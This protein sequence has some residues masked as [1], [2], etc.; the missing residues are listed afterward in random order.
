MA[1]LYGAF[2]EPGNIVEKE[3]RSL[4]TSRTEVKSKH[5]DSDLGQ[6]SS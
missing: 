5:A 2:F 3:D 1:K 4:F 6:R